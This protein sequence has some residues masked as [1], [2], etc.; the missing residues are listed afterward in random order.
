MEFGN[1][2]SEIGTINWEYVNC[3]SFLNYVRLTLKF[4]SS[5]F[6]F[7][8][9][10]TLTSLLPHFLM[11]WKFR[12][13]NVLKLIQWSHRPQNYFKLSCSCLIKQSKCYSNSDTCYFILCQH[14]IIPSYVVVFWSVSLKLHSCHRSQKYLLVTNQGTLKLSIISLKILTHRFF[15]VISWRYCSLNFNIYH[16]SL[17]Q[18][19][20]IRRHT[21]TRALKCICSGVIFFISCKYC[22]PV[23]S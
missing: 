4:H 3:V 16:F 5:Q 13:I 17:G 9:L 10:F 1:Q 23:K 21:L 7:T 19:H 18:G 11:L 14:K 22:V 2:I 6:S 20:F 8:F 12:M 15:P